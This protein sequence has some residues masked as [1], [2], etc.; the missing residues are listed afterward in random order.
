V[1]TLTRTA[2][3]GSWF[4]FYACEFSGS[5]SLPPLIPD[6]PIPLIPANRARCSG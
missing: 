5:V 3:Y 1:S 6:V 4:N 2:D